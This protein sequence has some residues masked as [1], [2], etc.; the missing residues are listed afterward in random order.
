M[1]RELLDLPDGVL[2]RFQAWDSG[3]LLEER[4]RL[5]GDFY[6]ID[7]STRFGNWFS[8]LTHRLEVSS[9]SLLKVSASLLLGVSYGRASRH[10]RRERTVARARWFNDQRVASDAHFK[11]AFFSIAFNVPGASSLPPLPGTVIR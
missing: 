8:N 11:S 1:A 7:G 6:V 5:R 4:R 10:I 2:K 3:A 9:Q